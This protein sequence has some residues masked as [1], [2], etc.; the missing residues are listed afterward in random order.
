MFSPSCANGHL[1]VKKPKNKR[2]AAAAAAQPLQP[3]LTTNSS[4][5]TLKKDTRTWNIISPYWLKTVVAVG[6]DMM[7][8]LSLLYYWARIYLLL[9]AHFQL[10]ASENSSLSD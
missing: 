5:K 10:T 7:L 1:T 8:M 4:S 9:I 6:H 3:F 2:R